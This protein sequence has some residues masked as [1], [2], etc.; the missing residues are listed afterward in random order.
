M[1]ILLSLL[2]EITEDVL[3]V[4]FSLGG[5]I[6]AASRKFL[7]QKKINETNEVRFSEAILAKKTKSFTL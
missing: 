6:V 5:L 2:P 4:S 1:K 3:G 7:R